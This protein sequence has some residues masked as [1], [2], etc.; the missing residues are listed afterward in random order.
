MNIF[1]S[2]SRNIIKYLNFLFLIIFADICMADVIV[3][4]PLK[5][6]FVTGYSLPTSLQKVFNPDKKAIKIIDFKIVDKVSN[7]LSGIINTL[8]KNLVLVH[9]INSASFEMRSVFLSNYFFVYKNKN[10]KKLIIMPTMDYHLEGN[11]IPKALENKIYEF[12]KVSIPNDL[13]LA[14]IKESLQGGYN[15][16][17]YIFRLT[18][19]HIF[20]NNPNL[21]MLEVLKRDVE[22]STTEISIAKNHGT[23]KDN[24]A[25]NDALLLAC[26]NNIL[27][28]EGKTLTDLFPGKKMINFTPEQIEQNA[29]DLKFISKANIM[30]INKNSFSLWTK[31]QKNIVFNRVKVI[32]V[33]FSYVN[34][35]LNKKIRD[36]IIDQKDVMEF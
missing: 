28:N 7:E 20:A 17:N 4:L 35:Y 14:S 22:F 33:D 16:D 29:L 19:F 12:F 9:K 18:G 11:L 23:L 30:I 34:K 6:T 25:F 31:E 15:P 24:L 1:R 21:K 10:T 26:E 36:Y 2:F 3:F 5:S 32:E 8:E 27:L 13:K